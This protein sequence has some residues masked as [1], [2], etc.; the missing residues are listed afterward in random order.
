[1]RPGSGGSC[2]VIVGY[3]VLSPRQELTVAPNAAFSLT[4]ANASSLNGQAP[5]FY[6]NAANINAGTISDLRLSSNI[7]TNSAAQTFSGVKTFSTA[8]SFTASGSPF[9]VSNSGLVSNLNADLLDGLSSAAFAPASHTHDATALIS[10]NSQ[11]I[12]EEAEVTI[13]GNG[14]LHITCHASVYLNAPANSFSSAYLELKETT[15]AEVLID[16]A[17]VDFLGNLT[18]GFTGKTSVVSISHTI[19]VTAGVRRFKVRI[20]HSGSGYA[21]IYDRSGAS[22]L[23]RTGITLMYFPRGL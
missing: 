6:T 21:L 8:P 19:P 2:A 7:A 3:T 12:I 15:G 1:V 18:T 11:T 22:P 20:R 14:F 16:E 4:A 10:N 23:I 13:P 5:S 17:Y 9:S